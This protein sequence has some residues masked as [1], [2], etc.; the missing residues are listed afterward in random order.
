VTFSSS[1]WNGTTIE[2][3]GIVSQLYRTGVR[4]RLLLALGICI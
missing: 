4:F 2:Y 1:L 3:L